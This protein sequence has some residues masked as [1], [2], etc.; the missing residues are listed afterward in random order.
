VLGPKW[1]HVA[2][3]EGRWDTTVADWLRLCKLVDWQGCD[4]NECESEEWPPEHLSL[5]SP[6]CSHTSR[7]ARTHAQQIAEFP[8][9]AAQPTPLHCRRIANKPRQTTRHGLAPR[10]APNA[11]HQTSL[12]GHD[13]GCCLLCAEKIEC[14]HASHNT[15]DKA[16]F[17]QPSSPCMPWRWWWWVGGRNA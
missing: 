9:P 5:L 12:P 15:A 13:H 2:I 1:R 3:L 8:E 4:E 6:P 14:T 16:L 7:S 10:D 11:R 17:A